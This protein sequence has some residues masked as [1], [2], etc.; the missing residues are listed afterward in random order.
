[1]F[2]LAFWVWVIVGIIALII[3]VATV[4]LVSIWVCL[5]CI[6]ACICNIL[7]FSETAQVVVFTLTTAFSFLFL[8][9]LAKN[10]LVK[11]ENKLKT[12]VESY[13]GKTAV[14]T[15]EIDNITGTGEVIAN[16]INWSAKS[17]DD[18]IK[19]EKDSIVI[20][21]KVEGS[22]LIVRIK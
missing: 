15:K 11:P 17:T 10:K 3:E 13:I 16:G 20:I 6:A 18:N 8:Y 12:N 5:G 14:C 1:M 4:S 21:E 2:N 7:G 9:K 19:I 22:K